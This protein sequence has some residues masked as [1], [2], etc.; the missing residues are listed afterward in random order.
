[1][2]APSP[3]VHVVRSE[4]LAKRV[5]QERRQ[6]ENRQANTTTTKLRV[7]LPNRVSVSPISSCIE[8]NSIRVCQINEVPA[9]TKHD[10][11]PRSIDSSKGHTCGNVKPVGNGTNFQDNNSKVVSQCHVAQRFEGNSV[12]SPKEIQVFPAKASVIV[13]HATQYT[14]A[15]AHMS[16][17]SACLIHKQ[18]KTFLMRTTT[19]CQKWDNNP[20]T[21]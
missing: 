18:K 10:V 13:C 16:C 11:L 5:L 9:L 20:E 19:W 21:S 1:M 14:C 3:T 15:C 12:I 8:V 4:H 7:Q 2:K 6:Q 17:P